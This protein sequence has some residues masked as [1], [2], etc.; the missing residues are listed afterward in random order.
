MSEDDS[1]DRFRLCW[2]SI[3]AT[4]DSLC[5]Q[6]GIT[7]LEDARSSGAANTEVVEILIEAE[8]ETEA[9]LRLQGEQVR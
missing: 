8:A 6:D 1:H 4:P 5:L 2:C 9:V 7:A 3:G